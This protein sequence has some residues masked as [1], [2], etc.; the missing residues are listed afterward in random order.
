MN[1]TRREALRLGLI[2]GGGLLLSQ[3]APHSASASEV[4]SQ[5][6]QRF[7]QPFKTP[8]VL[9]PKRS[10]EDGKRPLD[11]YEITMQKAQVQLTPDLHTEIWGYNGLFPG[12]VI[13][14]RGGLEPEDKGRSSLI[15]FINKLGNDEEGNPINTS[16]HLHGMASLPQY[17]GYAED[18]TPPEYFKDYFYP[19]DR[20]ATIW[21]HDHAID[22][23][24]RNVY[25]GLAGMYIVEDE[26][27]RRLNLPKGEFDVPL[28]LQDREI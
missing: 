19:N 12:P 26:A 5:Q 1:I 9:Q 4:L 21:Y 20:A 23:T 7:Q 13:R 16:V 8:P 22:K 6:I 27:E 15:R 18:L 3:G 25:M 11:V 17:D 28:I 10:Y 2:G 14:Q 24:S